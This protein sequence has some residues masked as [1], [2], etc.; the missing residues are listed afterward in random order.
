MPDCHPSPAPDSMGQTM[1]GQNCDLQDRL[2]RAYAN[3]PHIPGAADYP[4]RWAVRAAAY[5]DRLAGRAR[6]DLAYG[7]TERQRLDLFLPETT[8]KGL[9]VFLH[10]GYWLAF[11]RESW[12]FLAEG[13]NRLGWAVAI[14]S[15]TLAPDARI[16]QMTQEIRRAIDAAH[17]E[18]P[19]PVV[20]A[21]HSAGGHLAARMACSDIPLAADLR[22]VVPISPLADLAPIA[23]SSMNQRLKLDA[24]EVV[25][26]SPALLARKPNVAAHVWVGAQE[27]PA[28][29]YQ[30]RL[31]SEVWDCPWTAD[32]GRHHF[33][34]VDALCDPGSSLM[35]EIVAA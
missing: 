31:L 12:S 11:G 20:V 25:A 15:Y 8:A 16:G 10:G 5:R 19:R 34:V 27:R 6:L 26:E 28:F 2:D 29:L 3:A 23:A 13:A 4:A 21:G 7:S 33:D 17:A 9:L 35:A 14:P 30:A 22:K 1:T 24:A 32:P 18:V